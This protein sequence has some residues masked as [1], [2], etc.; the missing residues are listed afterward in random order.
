MRS[1]I[2][3]GGPDS[4]E[5]VRRVAE[6]GMEFLGLEVLG[7]LGLD[8]SDPGLPQ[9]R[10]SGWPILSGLEEALALPGLEQVIELKGDEAFLHRLY[11]QVPPGVRVMDLGQTRA[12]THL[13]AVFAASQKEIDWRATL[14]RLL[15]Q[16]R[17]EL[18]QILDSLPDAVLV[19]NRE[20]RLERVNARF[21]ELTGIK[22]KDLAQPCYQ[23]S[24]FCSRL[25]TR[26]DGE[27]GC[28]F[29]EVEKAGQ[30]IQFIH[31]EPG[32]NGQERYF[33]II[34][35]PLFD[36]Q[37][38]VEK[39]IETARVITEQV[40][41]YRRTEESERLFRQLVDNTHDMI[42]IKDLEGRYLVINHPA[43][44]LF[45][46]TPMD[47]LGRTDREILPPRL[48]EV[49]RAKDL[50]TIHSGEHSSWEETLVIKG[51]RSFLHTVRFPL[52]DYKAEISGVC[53]ISREVTEQKRLQE[54]ILQSEKL[55]AVG[56]LAASVAH[57]L[58]NP[59]T[60]IL[61]FA[62]ELLEEAGPQA[63][64]REDCGIIVREAM[65][66]RRIVADLLDYA[67]IRIP[68]RQDTDINQVVERALT[69]VVKQAAFHDVEFRLD[70][71]AGLPLVR[72]DPAQ[73]QQVFLNLIINAAEA[74][75][76]AGYL[77]IA[78]WQE[79]EE[80]PVKVAVEDT[81]RGIPGEKFQEIFEP[82]YST[83]GQRG[84]GLGLSVVRTI[85]EQHGGGIE[86][87]SEP[88]RGSKFTVSLPFSS[89]K[90]VRDGHA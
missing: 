51:R 64:I 24:P 42:T 29:D 86:L 12:L 83:K 65:R 67:R 6:G 5:L 4:A 8:P 25:G 78:S 32:Q 79:K 70:L 72:S 15:R 53:S 73:M 89:A 41:E 77:T 50:K 45:G 39:I 74:M 10:E 55:A 75:E 66:C 13:E 90:E 36:D 80:G 44:A 69:M 46:M 31:F 82:F 63:Q 7:Y 34:Q 56:K 2:I 62:E 37:G 52:R 48:A 43:A 71:S 21:L 87:E 58:N 30:P 26:E 17:E 84:N 20:M 88:G 76:G 3:G 54:A 18:Q 38:R 40:H 28:A 85:I 47:C 60:G 11:R 81:G 57:E 9:A 33:R 23:V 14:E 19:T 35:N 1:V 27:K 16:E 61:T 68:Q 59:L 49:V 22:A